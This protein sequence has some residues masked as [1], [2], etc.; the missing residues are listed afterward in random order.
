MLRNGFT[1]GYTRNVAQLLRKFAELHVFNSDSF[2]VDDSKERDTDTQH[3]RPLCVACGSAQCALGVPASSWWYYAWRNTSRLFLG[4]PNGTDGVDR[5]IDR[6]TDGYRWLQMATDG[7]SAR[8]SVGA[9]LPLDAW[10]H[11]F[12]RSERRPS[13]ACAYVAPLCSLCWDIVKLLQ[14]G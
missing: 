13:G 5:S 8:V 9:T 4:R 7:C 14:R 1:K 6:S 11:H 3:V 2:F 10:H 12:V